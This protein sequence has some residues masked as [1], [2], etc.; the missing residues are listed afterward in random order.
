MPFAYAQSLLLTIMLMKLL[1]VLTRLLSDMFRLRI[2]CALGLN[3]MVRVGLSLFFSCL[4]NCQGLKGW[5]I[6]EQ[7]LV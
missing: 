5:Q 6:L 4:P 7:E 3:I 1:S 2:I